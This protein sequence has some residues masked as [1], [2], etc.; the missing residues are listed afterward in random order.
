MR[1][2]VHFIPIATTVI[3]LLFARVVFERY[4]ERGGTHLLWWSIGILLY[5]VGT[6]TESLVTLFGWHAVVFKAWYISGALLGGAPLLHRFSGGLRDPL[7]DQLRPRRV[8]S[9]D[10]VGF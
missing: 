4:R 5:G 7:T 1:E 3:A 10:G 6:L 8:T 9:V 2:P